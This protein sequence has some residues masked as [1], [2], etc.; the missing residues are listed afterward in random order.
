M[1]W[2]ETCPMNERTQFVL[3][4]QQSPESMAELCR[5]FGIA[6]KTGYKWLRRFAEEGLAGLADRPHTPHSCPHAISPQ[7][8]EALLAFR[9]QHPTWGPK[10]LAPLLATL[11][12]PL[13]A[14][15]LSTIGDLLRSAGLAVP[16]RTRR[17]A[18]RRSQPLA[19]ATAANRVWTTDF[20]GVFAL[21]DR[22]RCYP[23]TISD[24]FS[25]YF[26]RCQALDSMA[27]GLVQPLFEATFREFGLPETIR[28]DNGPPFASVG[29]GGLTALSIWWVKL[30]IRLERIDL[31]KPQQ[32]GR[33]E[34]LHR[35]LK[36]ETCRPPAFSLRA[37]QRR[38]D[39]FRQ[40]YNHQRP[41][42]ALGQVPPARYYQPSPHPFPSRLPE[43][44]YPDADLVRY[45]RRNGAIRWRSQEVY[46]GQVLAG[47]PVAL[48]QV[49]DALWRVDFGQHILGGARPGS[50]RLVA[51]PSP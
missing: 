42:E 34:R 49:G 27:T 13:E 40:V 10:K 50:T 45:V 24:A 15:A 11:E 41:H 37:Q 4:H 36:E 9:A 18:P 33:L 3:A 31:G 5:Q 17:H 12:P 19:H 7:V 6:R 26:L 47:E 35:T 46:V 38:F 16:Q 14:P 25:R 28:S 2:L 21:G 43:L 29:V 22:G 1:S 39:A 20:K 23:L 32:N 30:G 44:V 8:R 48:T 51:L